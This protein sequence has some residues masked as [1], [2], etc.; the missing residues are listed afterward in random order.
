MPGYPGTSS[1]TPRLLLGA[2]YKWERLPLPHPHAHRV[3]IC[4]L[5][6]LGGLK[7]VMEVNPLNVVSQG[8]VGQQSPVSVDDVGRK[9]KGVLFSVHDLGVGTI[10]ILKDSSCERGQSCVWEEGWR[11]SMDA[12]LRFYRQGLLTQVFNKILGNFHV[13]KVYILPN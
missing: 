11:G 13:Q 12:R 8:R 3:K 4:S 9:S 2:W 10:R 5:T 7:T 6:I 1:Q